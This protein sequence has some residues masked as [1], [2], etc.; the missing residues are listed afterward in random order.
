MLALACASIL[1]YPS[2]VGVPAPGTGS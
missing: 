2:P 1:P